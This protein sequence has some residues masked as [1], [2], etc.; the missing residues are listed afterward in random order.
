MRDRLLALFRPRPRTAEGWL[1]RL[2]RPSVTP[3][4]LAAFEAW[5][6]ADP[7]HLETYQRL[8]ALVAD[9]RSLKSSFTAELAAI[10]ARP[11]R[12]KRA[13]RWT[14]AA[15]ALGTVAA[16]AAAIAW[17]PSAWNLATDPLA[18]A[19]VISTAVGEIRDVTLS[20]GSR[21]T[22]DTNTRIRVQMSASARRLQLDGGQA[23]FAVAHDADRPFEVALADRAV[24]VTGTRFTTSLIRGHARVALLEGSITLE[25]R[26]ADG[27]PLRLS[28][29]EAMRFS[30]GRSLQPQPRFD[31]TTAPDWR[32]RRRIYLDVPLSDVLADLSRYT[33]QSIV[34]ADPAVGRMRVTAVVPLE[35]PGTVVGSI[36]RLLPVTVAEVAPDRV[37]VRAQEVR[38][39]VMRPE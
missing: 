1:A 4:E 20:D 12:R 14:W 22:L 28:P 8:K 21:V 25:P 6:E 27:G 38:T 16:A 9:T 3:G 11:Q 23:Y 7:A 30:A 10:P 5:L 17:L 13:R 36:D 29:G 24:V 19:Q 26:G 34:V 18:G 31:P 32:A 15:P 35:G 39:P 33:T 2:G 37:E